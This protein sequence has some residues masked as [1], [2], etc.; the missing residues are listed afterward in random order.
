MI[1]ILHLLKLKGNE[2]VLPVL[3]GPERGTGDPVM[4]PFAF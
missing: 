3:L 1:S 2:T 4:D